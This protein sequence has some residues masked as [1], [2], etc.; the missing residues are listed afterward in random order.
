MINLLFNSVET[1]QNPNFTNNKPKV[2]EV[3]LFEINAGFTEKEA[4]KALSS[5]NDIIK[6]YYGFIER[7]TAKNENGK[8]V[9]IIYW[10]DIN[11]AKAAATDLVQNEK[12][13]AVFSI[14]KSKSTQMYHFDTFNQFEE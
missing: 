9:D 7:I 13:V 4:K 8:Y 14:I 3:V 1:N 12:A 2:V 6:L 5:L 11:S 10:R